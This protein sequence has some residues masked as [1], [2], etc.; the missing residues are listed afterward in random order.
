MLG[1]REEE[2]EGNVELVHPSS[3]GPP[4]VGVALKGALSSILAV[5]PSSTNP[6][7]GSDMNDLSKNSAMQRQL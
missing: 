7:G 3:S 2:Q 1:K 6:A 5:F 4:P